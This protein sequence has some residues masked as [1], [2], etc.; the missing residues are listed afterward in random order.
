[1]G[2]SSGNSSTTSAGGP[3]PIPLL[4]AE[5]QIFTPLGYPN[6]GGAANN[7]FSGAGG[8]TGPA[9]AAYGSGQNALQ[10]GQNTW[11]VLA[12]FASPALQAGFD[13]QQALYQRT[14]QQ[15]QD[16]TNA[17]NAMS[18]VAST[19]YGAS[20]ANQANSHFNIDW[21]NQQLQRQQM[22]AQTA[23]GLLGA[24]TNALNAG[25]SANQAGLQ[26][27]SGITQQ[28]IADFLAYLGQNTANSS[29]FTGAVNNTYA[30]ALGGA[31]LNN[32]AAQQSNASSLAGLSGLGS[33]FGSALKFF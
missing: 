11:D 29:A 21:Q 13:P 2:G 25:T 28:Q 8:L 9:N 32:Q 6:T 24:G 30:G 17:Q 23:E 7:A 22:G 3:A 27:G 12:P 14:L 16:Q 4:N 33:L 20:L 31:G 19:P 26:L 1:M 15:V 18:G 5:N 10:A